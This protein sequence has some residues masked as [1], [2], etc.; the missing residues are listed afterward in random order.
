VENRA[1][2]HRP[3]RRHLLPGETASGEPGNALHPSDRIKD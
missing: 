1:P 3:L 2:A